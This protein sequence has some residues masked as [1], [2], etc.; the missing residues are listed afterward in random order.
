M[1]HCTALHWQA[2]PAAWAWQP[3]LPNPLAARRRTISHSQAS[4]QWSCATEATRACRVSGS[5]G[6]L[7]SHSESQMPHCG[8]ARLVGSPPAC[9]GATVVLRGRVWP[10]LVQQQSELGADGRCNAACYL[11]AWLRLKKPRCDLCRCT[12]RSLMEPATRDLQLRQRIVQALAETLR[13]FPRVF[14]CIGM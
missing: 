2:A 13:S 1:R 12:K 14:H 6:G 9:D 7:S 4:C 3:M 11:R 10:G 8:P 5:N